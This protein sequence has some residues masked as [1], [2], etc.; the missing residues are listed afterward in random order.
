[1]IVGGATV[2]I[3]EEPF[4]IKVGEPPIAAPGSE[5]V[6]T[7]RV[8]NPTSESAFNMVIR[9][10][11]P[12]GIEIVSGTATDGSL[13]IVGQI[14]ELNLDELVAGGRVTITLITRVSD[15]D[16]FPQIINRACVTSSSNPSPRCAQMSFLRAGQLP[17][18]GDT[19]FIYTM[20]RWG[21]V[22]ML[23]GFMLFGL[24][25]LWRRMRSI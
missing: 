4:I 14:I 7:I 16:V 24:S 5:I 22:I 2:A 25:L 19:P 18:T 15:S 8:I 11:M 17:N 23:T 13:D 10:A 9:D 20:L 1:V 3:V 21:F 6:Y 12:E